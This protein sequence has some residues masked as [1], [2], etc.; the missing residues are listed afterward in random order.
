MEAGP[1]RHAHEMNLGPDVTITNWKSLIDLIKPSFLGC[2][3]RS[4]SKPVLHSSK[5]YSCVNSS[6]VISTHR[7]IDGLTD[8]PLNDDEQAFALSC[9]LNQQYRFRCPTENQCRSPIQSPS[10]CDGSS[11]RDV[12]ELLFYELCDRF[13][14]LPP[15]TIDGRSH[16]DET[17][18]ESWQ[19]NN[20]YTRCDGFWNCE[21]GEDEE[22]CTRSICPPHFHPCVLPENA[23]VVCLAAHR[24]QNGS[25]DC[26]GA[27]DERQY[28][29]ADATYSRTYQFRCWNDTT[30]LL[31]D[32]LCN[33]NEDCPLGD[34]EYFC[35]NRAGLCGESSTENLTDVEYLLCGVGNIYHT[36]LSLD[37]ALTYPSLPVRQSIPMISQSTP[38]EVCNR[39]VDVRLALKTDD[40]GSVCFCPPN[41]YGDRCQ[42]QNQ[43]VSLTLTLATVD[44]QIIYAIVVTLFDEDDDRQIIHSF[45]QLIRVPHFHCGQ[46]VNIY[47]LFAH[48]PKNDS[49]SY[50]V[51]VDAFDKSSLIHLASWHLSIPFVFLPVNRLAAFLTLPTDRT[52]H[53]C[54]LQCHNQGTCTKYLNKDRFFCRCQSGWSGARCD[55]PIDCSQCS[56]DSICLGA[57]ANRSICVCPPHKFGPRCLLTQTCPMNFCKNDGQCVVLDQRMT[58]DSY[59]CLCLEPFF[60]PN[61]DRVKHRI[62]ISLH[63]VEIPS[64]LFAYIYSNMDEHRPKPTF[65]VLEE[66]DDVP[67]YSHSLFSTSFS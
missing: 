66:I 7:L 17:D 41:Y 13:A 28:C 20:V 21:N 54:K 3:T 63:N 15:I 36:P 19:C 12:N 42:Y 48:R 51:R 26:L 5:L 16:S 40:S 59:A 60:G 45:E 57:V 18:C 47:L 43:R 55:R 34:D 64:H 32:N 52:S 2:T 8:C 46:R 50:S 58:D 10:V 24:V 31:A 27:S 53:P 1:C 33:D 22:K 65:I 37:T 61:C 62:D 9:S 25:I 35:G 39:G 44:E 14:D 23:T 38:R 67:E 49:K 56:T 30:C 4:F 11:H 6:K 29:R